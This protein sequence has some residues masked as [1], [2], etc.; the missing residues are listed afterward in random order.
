[1][2]SYNLKGICSNLWCHCWYDK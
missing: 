1:M 2:I